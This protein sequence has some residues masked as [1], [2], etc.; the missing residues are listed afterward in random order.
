[1]GMDLMWKWKPRKMTLIL[2]IDSRT[3]GTIMFPGLNHCKWQKSRV[4][5]TCCCITSHV[6]WL[7]RTYHSHAALSIC[8]LVHLNMPDYVHFIREKDRLRYIHAAWVSE[9]LIPPPTRVIRE[10]WN[11]HNEM[12]P[13]LVMNEWWYKGQW[14]GV[15]KQSINHLSE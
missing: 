3:Q 4:R 11:G 10:P 5:V 6:N 13:F 14:S 1:M 9:V 15:H 8:M 2:Y 12:I 7:D